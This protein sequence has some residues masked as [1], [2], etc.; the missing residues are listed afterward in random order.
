MSA[1][2]LWLVLGFSGQAIFAGRFLLQWLSSEREK[3]SVIPIGFW[4]MSIAGSVLLLLYAI[5]R[6]DPVFIVGQL[7]GFM[8]YLRNLQLIYQRRKQADVIEPENRS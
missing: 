2:D 8:V 7:F 6:V 1:E 4:Y 5:H 3:K